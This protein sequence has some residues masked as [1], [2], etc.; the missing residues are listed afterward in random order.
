MHELFE[1]LEEELTP[2]GYQSIE[3][4]G[5]DNTQLLTL[6]CD[7][8]K[9]RATEQRLSIRAHAFFMHAAKCMRAVRKCPLP[10]KKTGH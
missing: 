8:A 10:P 6:I 4:A 5:L 1:E 7:R 9:Q 3:V 2:F